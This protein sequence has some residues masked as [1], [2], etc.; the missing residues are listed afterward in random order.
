MNET[1]TVGKRLIPLEHIAL[2]E[3]FDATTQLPLP[4]ERSFQ[5]R[6]VLVDRDSVLTDEP[7]SAFPERYGFRLLSEDGIATNPAVHFSVEAFTPTEG[8]QPT[9]PFRTRLMWRDLDG[10]KQSK[11]LLAPPETVLAIAVR[12]ESEPAEAPLKQTKIVRRNRRRAVAPT[13]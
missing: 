8:F 5:A 7:L 10:E 3:P 4:T 11:L 9:K 2:I 12:G 13:P 1:V 6:V